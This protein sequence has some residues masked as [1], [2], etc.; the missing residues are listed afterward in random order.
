MALLYNSKKLTF[1]LMQRESKLTRAAQLLVLR[2]L[3]EMH[4]RDFRGL[5][6]IRRK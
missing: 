5:N 4:T 1:D 6:S 2:N 3:P